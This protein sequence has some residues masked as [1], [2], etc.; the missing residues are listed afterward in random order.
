MCTHRYEGVELLLPLLQRRPFLLLLQLL[1]LLS[2]LLLP[3][4]VV[5]LLAF[6][7]LLRLVGRLLFAVLD[8]GAGARVDVVV[9]A[10]TAA[11]RQVV[12][13]P[14]AEK[15][16]V[17]VPALGDGSGNCGGGV[18]VDAGWVVVVVVGRGR[19]RRGAGRVEPGVGGGRRRLVFRRR[20]TSGG[21]RVVV[22]LVR[23]LEL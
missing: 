14:G 22:L 12:V 13:G 20:A 19:G 21:P 5:L 16:V 9:R 10:G 1:L 6:L 7:A 11:V 4:L 8:V 15:V 23:R 18:R 17:L 3:G 2:L